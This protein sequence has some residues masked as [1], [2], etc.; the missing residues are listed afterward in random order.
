MF[1]ALAGMDWAGGAASALDGIGATHTRGCSAVHAT[2]DQPKNTGS[3]ACGAKI[4]VERC[5]TA[6]HQ[7]MNKSNIVS[8][9]SRPGRRKT[10][11][12]TGFIPE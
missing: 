1:P 2:Q 10:A 11:R 4:A 7:K 8:D 9:V 12:S 5:L 6:G 3:T